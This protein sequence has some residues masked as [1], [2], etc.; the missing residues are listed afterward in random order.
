MKIAITNHAVD[1]Y[2]E[3]AEGAK[4]FEKESV[5]EVIRKLVID[6]FKEGVVRDHPTWKNRR[7]VPFK[8]GDSILY[9][10]IGPNTT[11]YPADLAVIGVLY[12]KEATSGKVGMSV[13]LGDIAPQLKDVTTS[14]SHPRYAVFVGVG[15]TI[16]H[17]R[18]NERTEVE[19]LLKRRGSAEAAVYVLSRDW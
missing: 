5:R 9:L 12:E 3:R 1:R 8:S 19:E 18:M 14:S 4:G 15:E 11:S 16:E 10:S 2:I 17:Y 6:G 13:T 7:I